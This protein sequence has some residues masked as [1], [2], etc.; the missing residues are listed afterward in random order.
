MLP[1]WLYGK[2]K[3]KL[4]EI[5]GGGGGGTTYAAGDG[6]DISNGVISFDPATTPA[7]DPSKIDGLDDDLTALAPKTALSNPNILDNPWFTVNQRGQSTY[8]L[9][10]NKMTVDRWLAS[11]S[12]GTMIV[13]VSSNGLTI[14]EASDVSDGGFV[15]RINE[16]ELLGKIVTISIDDGTN[17]YHA[18]GTI[19]NVQPENWTEVCSVIT[20]GGI[21]AAL[22]ISPVGITAFQLQYVIRVPKD[23][24]AYTIRAVKLELG[25]VSTLAMDAAPNYATELLKCQRYFYKTLQFNNNGTIMSPN[26]CV[27]VATTQ[28]QGI[29]FPTQ[30]RDNPNIIINEV[31]EFD[32][33]TPITGVAAQWVTK[34]GITIFSITGATVGSLYVVDFEAS[35]EL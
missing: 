6:I 18:T 35:A 28:L 23:N 27:A 3:S 11:V 32:S 30:M 24:T 12:S 20:S 15:E 2:S 16:P 31:V 4:Q 13:G 21:N 9:T 25:S 29:K 1:N 26:Q 22:S 10:E 19:P 34:E 33:S 14:T 5:L 7:I 8:N 17:I